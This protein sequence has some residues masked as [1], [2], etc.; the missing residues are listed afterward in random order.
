MAAVTAKTA[1][2]NSTAH[3]QAA[4]PRASPASVHRPQG[5]RA[6]MARASSS[7]PR[8]P[9]CCDSERQQ[10]A[11][12]LRRPVVRQCRLWPQGAGR[13]SRYKQMMEL[14]YY[15]TFFKT[16][17]PPAVEL[18]K[19]LARHRRPKQLNHVFYGLS[20]SD[21]NDTI[22]RMVRHYW[23]LHGQEDARRPSSAARTAITAAP[24]RRRRLGGMND[25]HELGRP[26]AAGLRAHHAALLV[27]PRAATC[28]RRS[29]AS[30]RR[31]RSRTRSSSS[32]ADN[33]RG[34]HR[35]ADPGRRRRDHSAGRPTGRR[36]SA[37]AGSTTCC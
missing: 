15:N 28:R 27:R 17:T 19:M 13:R 12:R 25:M 14:P 11:R 29:S 24:W 2:R 18:S 10:A 9:I 21:A 1:P 26:A 32:G 34:L 3:W 23:N 4:R 30:R 33:V 35:R 22:A 6:S 5:A 8:A 31:A 36:S 20:G 7:R 37:S 16:T